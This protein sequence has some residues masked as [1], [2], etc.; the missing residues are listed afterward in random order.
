MSWCTQ[1]SPGRNPDW[2]TE[3]MFLVSMKLKTELNISFPLI[4]Y[5]L[6]IKTPVCSFFI[7][8]LSPFLWTG[9]ILLFFQTLGN[10]PDARQ[11]SKSKVYGLHIE[12]THSLSIF[13]DISSFPWALFWS[14]F[15]ISWKINSEEM[16]K[17]LSL[18]SV[19]W[20]KV[21]GSTLL[22]LIVVH[23]L[24]KYLLNMLALTSNSVISSSFTSRGGIL[25]TFF[26]FHKVLSVAQYVFMDLEGSPSF[27]P[28][29]IK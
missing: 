12:G 6:L 24:A 16:L 28:R 13:T 14:R 5:K 8:Y 25:G 4:F 15:L 19:K 1:K 27:F 10:P 3:S 23:W 22:L 2:W 21:E 11:F 26:P 17:E 18:S 7:N 29:C 20:F 9:P